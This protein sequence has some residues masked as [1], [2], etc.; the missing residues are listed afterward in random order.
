M[1]A[2]GILDRS[3]DTDV[4]GPPSPRGTKAEETLLRM[5]E[6]RGR[7]GPKRSPPLDCRLLLGTCE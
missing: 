5:E 3:V 4:L 1:G 6:V 2:I 7:T